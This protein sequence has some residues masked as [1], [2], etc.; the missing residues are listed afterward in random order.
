MRL[1]W[2]FEDKHFALLKSPQNDTDIGYEYGPATSHPDWA[3]YESLT[4]FFIVF[5]WLGHTSSKRG[6]SHLHI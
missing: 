1:G 6:L 2:D 5:A 4:D 3:K